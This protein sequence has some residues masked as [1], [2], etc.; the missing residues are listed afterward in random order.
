[1]ADFIQYVNGPAES[2]WGRKR[3]ADGHP[4]PYDLRHVELGNEERV[5][6]AY[7]KQFA[8]L[9][10]AIWAKDPQ[11]T[12]IVGDFVYAKPIEDPLKFSGAESGITSFVGQKKILDLARKH[13]REVWFDVH[14]GTDGPGPADDFKAL[15]SYVA[16][17]GKIAAGAK[18]K[19]VVFEFNAANRQQR[20]ALANALAINGIARDGRIP[21]AT[22]AN[23]LQPDGQN[24]NGW[25]Q[26]L[27]FLNPSRVWLQP[28]GYVTQMVSRHYQP[29][30]AKCDV[31]GGE[32]K[33]DVTATCSDDGKT[34]VLQVVNLDKKP[35]LARLHLEGF[36]PVKPTAAVEEL[37]GPLDATN[38]ADNPERIRPRKAEWRHEI[39]DERARYAFPPYSF[40]VLRWE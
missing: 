22:S 17:L 7:Y 6:A 20:R 13:G 14:V 26:G 10:T 5:D 16:A 30:R 25:D 35:T 39:K 9:A 4:Q 37:A 32:G 29:R 3:A 40:T 34:L 23:C 24:D 11:V 31:N 8:A 15:P 21:I 36:T 2:E 12:L 1:M 33:L 27:L 38:S 19:V 18:H 28:P